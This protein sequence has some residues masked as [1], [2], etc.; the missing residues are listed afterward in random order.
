MISVIAVVGPTA[1][2]K[3]TLAVELAKHFDAEI[4]SFDSMQ[5]YEGMDIATAKPTF[6]EMQ[7]VPH[8]M[9]S[10]I[11][12]DEE[13]SV[14]KYKRLADEIIK[15]I[16]VRGKRVVLV[17]GTGLYLDALIDNI[18]FLEVDKTGV[19]EKFCKEIEGLTPAEMYERLK[20]V[21]PE[22][23]D[24]I[25]INNVARVAR[26]L[27]VYYTTGYTITHQVK[28]SRKNPSKY[29]AIYIGL[30]VKNREYLY[31]RIN[32]RIDDMLENGL[33]D[34]VKEYKSLGNT[35]CQAIGIKELVPYV[36]GEKTLEE[37]LESLKQSTRRYAKRQLTWFRRNDRIH[38]FYID[39]KTQKEILK[40]A[41]EII[42]KEMNT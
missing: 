10:A 36:N 31:D 22:S 16:D 1:S 27:K 7:G 24:R 32:K 37:C 29:K 23:A 4:L 28:E 15:D 2:G 39:E 30:N 3:T 5:L 38:W 34:E 35:S 26:A 41:I 25:H 8:H 13:M 20:E 11:P 19:E 17:G 6:S 18:E 9:I 42:E 12:L 40:E 21:D 14:A 33:L